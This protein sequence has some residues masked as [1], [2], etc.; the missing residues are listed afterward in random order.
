MDKECIK[1]CLTEDERATFE[2]DGLLVIK[3]AACLNGQG[4]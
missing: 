4:F 2:R 1:H 3:D